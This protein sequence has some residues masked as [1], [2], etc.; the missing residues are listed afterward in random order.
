MT[1][2]SCTRSGSS[3]ERG[4]LGGGPEGR[5]ASGTS[6]CTPR[7]SSGWRAGRSSTAKIDL[8]HQARAGNSRQVEGHV[9]GRCHQILLRRIDDRSCPRRCLICGEPFR[10]QKSFRPSHASSSSSSSLGAFLIL[11]VF[12]GT[13]VDASVGSPAIKETIGQFGAAESL[14]SRPPSKDG[15]LDEP[16]RARERAGSSSQPSIS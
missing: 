12:G 10:S 7:A 8:V 1:R 2:S 5:T 11:D 6:A 16:R 3:L 13:G 14:G 15:A 9:A 4:E